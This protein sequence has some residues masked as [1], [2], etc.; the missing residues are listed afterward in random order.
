MQQENGGTEWKPGSKY[1]I[2]TEAHTISRTC[3]GGEWVI[4]LWDKRSKVYVRQIWAA[5][6]EEQR[7]ATAELKIIAAGL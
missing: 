1:H 2:E 4:S 3:H 7:A 5:N 6:I